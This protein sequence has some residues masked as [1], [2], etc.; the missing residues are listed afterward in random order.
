ML[1]SAVMLK[2]M[3]SSGVLG[4]SVLFE[5]NSSC[6]CLATLATKATNSTCAFPSAL[7]VADVATHVS[8]AAPGQ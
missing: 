2:H 6:L 3:S 8:Q 5:L 1:A 7:L 4:L